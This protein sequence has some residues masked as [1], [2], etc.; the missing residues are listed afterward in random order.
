MN[1]KRRVGAAG[2]PDSTTHGSKRRKVSDDH[3]TET[4]TPQTTTEVGLRLLAHIKQSTDKNGR[5][6][7]TSFLHLP[8]RKKNPDYYKAI[9]LPIAI[10]TVEDKLK[11]YEYPTVTALESDL[12][13]M[14]SNAK[15]YNEKSSLIFADAE[16]IRKILSNN[17][18]KI[19]P[20]YKDPKYV[21]FPT[22]LPDEL[23]ENPNNE[24]MDRQDHQDVEGAVLSTPRDSHPTPPAEDNIHSESSFEG[25]SLQE[26]QDRII[27]E[28]IQLK[29]SQ[30]RDVASPFINKPDR[31]LYKEYYEIIKHP[32]SLRSIQKQVRGTDGR[33]S[34]PKTTAFPTWQSFEDE[35]EF[36]WRNAREFNED[37]SEIVAFAGILEDYF[38]R[39]VAEA[40]RFVTESTQANGDGGVPRI[41]L[42]MGAGKT[43][44]PSS[45]RLTLRLP[46][47]KPSASLN[48]DA[49][50]QGV[51]VDSEALRGQ[52]EIVKA[53]SN[54]QEVHAVTTPPITRSL[55]K[56]AASPISNSGK[57]Q[58]G[59]SASSSSR[60]T[61]ATFNNET[62]AL[63]DGLGV[64]SS[65]ETS[66]ESVKLAPTS[67]DK[68]P[69]ESAIETTIPPPLTGIPVDQSVS[70]R[71]SSNLPSQVVSAHSVP[72]VSPLDL[73]T[74]QP[75][76][77][78]IH[79]LISNVTVYTHTSLDPRRRFCLNIPASP[80][81]RQESL[82][83]NL[84]ASH[85]F[86]SIRLQVV[87]STPQRQ[88]KL[89]ALLGTQNFHVAPQPNSSATEPVYDLRLTPGITKVD[90]QMV[91]VH[92]RGSSH[93]GSSELEKEYERLTLFFNLLR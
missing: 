43:P 13:R 57:I 51:S 73:I 77:D 48:E 53:G 39:R 65:R 5:L 31:N 83:I 76:K 67:P 10:D 45:Q 19:N 64:V 56:P 36:I 91:S 7:A 68:T 60:S 8:D 63:P 79:A 80:T 82:V 2:S 72:H 74:R 15:F 12:K 40:K 34:L 78:G 6:I 62:Q 87:A 23:P 69:T 84:P 42:K 11:N 92:F 75:G 22:P 30:G 3:A 41:R 21:A 54:E 1:T 46:G 18:P 44:E 88:T 32:V 47:Q 55:R 4:E 93:P 14:V 52:Q 58:R 16:R 59:V 70:P 35:V 27:S 90:F 61:V 33:K 20:A 38:K 50:Q 71:L 28:L 26:A 25:D 66:Q 29:D 89:V 49:L 9:A 24:G 85:N 17:M 81:T 86:V 37:D